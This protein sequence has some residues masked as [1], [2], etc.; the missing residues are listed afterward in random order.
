MK[1]FLPL[2]IIGAFLALA[3][4]GWQLFG[5]RVLSVYYS[6]AAE[7]ARA[8]GRFDAAVEMM[9][10]LVALDPENRDLRRRAAALMAES[11]AQARAEY[12]LRQGISMGG[13]K[14]ASLTA[15]LSELYVSQDKLMDAV[16]LMD[17]SRGL[18]AQEIADMRPPM[19]E[20]DTAPGRYERLVS[21]RF[22][23]PEGCV[24]YVS[25]TGEYPSVREG[26]DE[27][28]ALPAGETTVRAVTVDEKGVVSALWTGVYTLDNLNYPIV[29]REPALEAAARVSLSKPAG[30]LYSRDLTGVTQLVIA[31]NHP[32]ETLEDLAAFTNLEILSLRGE[33]TSCDISALSELTKL[34]GLRLES[35][36]LDS[37]DLE[38][39]TALTALETLVLPNNH[40]TA[41]GALSGLTGLT[42]LDVSGNSITELAPLAPLTGLTLLNVS[43]N[44]VQALEPLKAMQAMRQLDLSSNRVASAGGLGTLTALTE[45]DLS[46]NRLRDIRALDSLTR[47]ERL[48]MSNNE[49][50]DLKPLG[51]LTELTELNLAVN[52]ISDL[53]PLQTLAALQTLIL[54]TNAVQAVAPLK[55][56]ASLEVLDLDK[57][58]VTS[59]EALRGLRRLRELRVESNKLTTLAPLLDCPALKS[60]HAIGNRVTVDPA[61]RA[62]GITVYA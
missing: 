24:C 4:V 2:L 25:L 29:F 42:G 11:G 8:D 28:A 38:T 50:D 34:K 21:L 36:G 59:V 27:P 60:V 12:H 16:A 46:V 35:M 3:F 17:G 51:K 62:K 20:P 26:W 32:Y 52:E 54:H 61:F 7:R 48:D 58:A 14:Q 53:A 49:L 6:G 44:S 41:L 37:V 15:A 33:G 57:N 19:P 39:L 10:R 1:R 23:A 5:S 30:D 18:S 56:C 31:E 40:L 45:L 55:D 9:E 43:R 47:L 22:A 13:P